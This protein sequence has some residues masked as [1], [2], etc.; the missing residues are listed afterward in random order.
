MAALRKVII[1]SDGACERNPGP[2]GWAAT[3]ACGPHRRE[4]SGGALA[5]TNNRMELQA[6]IEGLRALKERCAVDLFTDSQYLRDG[7]TRWIARWSTNGWRTKTKQPV[8]NEDL[9]R[10]LDALVRQHEVRWHWLKGHA[11]H[12]ENERCDSLA[13]SQI[14]RI[15]E[16]H[17]P[18][19]LRTALADFL[20]QSARQSGEQ[21]LLAPENAASRL[22]S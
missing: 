11:G 18:E 4:I 22:N 2:G 19:E 9:W 6:A 3:L 21:W 15:K 17:R 14:A 10:D 1:H 16:K 12:Q 13:V 5:T 20:A 8:K 7:I